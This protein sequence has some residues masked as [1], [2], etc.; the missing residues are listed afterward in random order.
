MWNWGKQLEFQT[1]YKYILFLLELLSHK[2]FSIGIDRRL[3]KEFEKKEETS[4]WV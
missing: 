2:L 4:E 1:K 3:S